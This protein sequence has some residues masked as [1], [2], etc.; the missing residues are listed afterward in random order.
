M[1]TNQV[2]TRVQQH[3]YNGPIKN[4]HEKHQK[5]KQSSEKEKLTKE[6]IIEN[7]KILKKGYERNELFI[8]EA[9]IIKETNPKINKQEENFVRTLKIF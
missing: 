1:T 4:H 2:A 5:D 6:L 9:I 7:M 8:L 3:V